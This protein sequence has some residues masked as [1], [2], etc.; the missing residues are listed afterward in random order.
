MRPYVA[1]AGLHNMAMMP[2]GNIAFYEDGDQSFLSMLDVGY[3]TALSPHPALD[4]GVALARPA[5]AAL[6]TEVLGTK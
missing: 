5:Y 2:C 6:F 4:E 3:M 1:Q